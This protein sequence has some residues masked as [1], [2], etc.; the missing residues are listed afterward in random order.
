MLRLLLIALFVIVTITGYSQ[1]QVLFYTP[2]TKG[3][4]YPKIK[5]DANGDVLLFGRFDNLNGLDAGTLIKLDQNGQV[6][7]TFHKVITDDIIDFLH[8]DASGKMIIWGGFTKVNG[9][10]TGNLA[11]LNSD[12]SLDNTFSAEVQK[13]GNP[14]VQSDG[15]I[16]VTGLMGYKGYQNLARLNTDGTVDES[17]INSFTGYINRLIVGFDDNIYISDLNKVYKIKPNGEIDA[18]FSTGLGT[19]NTGQISVL[20]HLKSGKLAVGGFFS[21]F[22]GVIAKSITLLNS[23]GSVDP[24]FNVGIGTTGQIMDIQ[25]R[26]NNNILIGGSFVTYNN[27]TAN[28]VELKLDGNLNKII[29]IVSTNVIETIAETPNQRIVISGQFDFVNNI[30]RDHVAL[31]NADN[32]LSLTFKPDISYN[33]PNNRLLDIDSNGSVIT[34]GF[35]GFGLYSGTEVIKKRLVKL[36]RLASHNATFT[37][38][39]NE[40]TNYTAMH[41][42]NDNKVI[43]SGM[44]FNN[45]VAMYRLNENGS[46]DN[47]FNVGSGPTYS[48]VQNPP[49][50]IKEKNSTLFACGQFDA[51][52][53]VTT[54]GLIA[55]NSNGSTKTIFLGPPKNSYVAN[56]D[57]QSD[58]KIIAV[59]SFPFEEGT[60]NIIRLN[61]NG[62]LDN[63]FTPRIFSGYANAVCVDEQDRI[64]LAGNI[65]SYSGGLVEHLLRLKSDGDID[66]TFSGKGFGSTGDVR[67]VELLSEGKIAVGGYFTEYDDQPANGFIILNNTGERVPLPDVNFDKSTSVVAMKKWNN[68]LYLAGRFATD[69][70]TKMYGVAKISFATPIVPLPPDEFKVVLNSAGVF[71]LSWK[72]KSPQDNGFIIERSTNSTSGFSVF[73]PLTSTFLFD[74]SITSDITYY[75]RIK[76]ITDFGDSDYSSVVSQIRIS[77]PLAPYELSVSQEKLNEL[78]LTW[79]KSISSE[80][81][82]IIER[83]ILNNTSF[84]RIDTVKARDILTFTDKVDPNKL[85]YYRVVAYNEGGNSS[86]SNSV[87][88]TSLFVPNKPDQLSVKQTKLD[89]MTLRWEDQSSNEDGFIIEKSEDNGATFTKVAAI[90]ANLNQYIDTSNPPTDFYTYRVKAFNKV[91]ESEYS[92]LAQLTIILGIEEISSNIQVYPIPVSKT[93]HVKMDETLKGTWRFITSNGQIISPLVESS[94]NQYSIDVHTFPKGLYILQFVQDN[95]VVLTRRIIVN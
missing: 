81:G 38:A 65:I 63:T 48:N 41:V 53:G 56:F 10:S 64:Y 7:P 46:V 91:A 70:N 78:L 29:A 36:D 42:Q 5:I 72:P 77:P 71:E 95:S 40:N 30:S 50:Y 3:L 94:V 39:L 23:D 57:I 75:Y 93:L 28:L 80:V 84:T 73:K 87:S 58:D 35:Y 37:S 43:V 14:A 12:G 24:Q 69:N 9:V 32:T 11:R 52:N 22:N 82:F 76:T 4:A 27:Q 18:T 74:N 45:N 59:G 90:A 13:V 55:L 68:T 67:A 31:F 6:V 19:E 47:S 60:M 1:K 33:N 79:K 51:F 88:I 49:F 85:Y 89:E 34:G 2:K 16:I 26:M 66:L 61:S 62:S 83:S 92:N 15:K 20:K 8:I 44:G 86:A 25:E 17:F 21:I 54:N